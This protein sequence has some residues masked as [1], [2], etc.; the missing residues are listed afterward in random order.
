MC[1]LSVSHLVFHV[2]FM[3]TFERHSILMLPGCRSQ[4]LAGTNMYLRFNLGF[5][6]IEDTEFETGWILGNSHFQ[7]R[8][9]TK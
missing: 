4:H 5:N 6:K 9:I 7:I 3:K 1:N 2:C 8:L